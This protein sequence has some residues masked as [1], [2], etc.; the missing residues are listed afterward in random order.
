V[1]TEDSKVDLDPESFI[2]DE[3]DVKEWVSDGPLGRRRIAVSIE[4]GILV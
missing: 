1:S 4:Q 2:R 3:V